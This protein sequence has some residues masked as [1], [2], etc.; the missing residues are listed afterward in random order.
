MREP[1]WIMEFVEGTGDG[2]GGPLAEDVELIL[3]ALELVHHHWRVRG[4]D[5]CQAALFGLLAHGG[6]Q[7]ADRVGMQLVL[8][9][10]EGE[11]GSVLR[12]G[13][14][15]EVQEPGLA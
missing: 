7:A 12:T 5:D 8:D 9:L 11:D 13:E 15:G 1:V 4:Q 6:E 10:I 14:G 2:L 3:V